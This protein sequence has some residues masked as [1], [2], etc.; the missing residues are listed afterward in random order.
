MT[1]VELLADESKWC[2]GAQ[3]R[4]KNGE[5]VDPNSPDACCWCLIGSVKRCY[6]GFDVQRVL[7]LVQDYLYQIEFC[8]RPNFYQT[9]ALWIWNDVSERT[10]DQVIQMFGCIG[11]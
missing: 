10:Y 11:A 1:V 7:E 3:A 2:Q 9:S 4:D 6:S 8:R 5:A